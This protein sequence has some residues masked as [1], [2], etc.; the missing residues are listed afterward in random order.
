MRNLPDFQHE[1]SLQSAR[2]SYPFRSGDPFWV[3]PSTLKLA[4]DSNGKPVLNLEMVRQREIMLNSERNGRF[5]LKLEAEYRL[6]EVLQEL[7]ENYPNAQVAPVIISGGFLQ[8]FSTDSQTN[9]PDKLGK[10]IELGWNGLQLIYNQGRLD[11]SST[12]WVKSLIAE[13]VLTIQ[14]R[15]DVE[16]EGVAPRVPQIASFD[17][18][19]LVKDIYQFMPGQPLNWQII[20]QY[21]QQEPEQMAVSLSTAP[22][23]NKTA[24]Q[25]LARALTDRIYTRFGSLIPDP[26]RGTWPLVELNEQDPGRFDWDLSLVEQVRRPIIIMFSPLTA[27]KNYVQAHGSESLISSVTVPPIPPGIYRVNVSAVLP[28]KALNSYAFG[29]NLETKANLP[30][31]PAQSQGARFTD[32]QLQKNVNLRFLRTETPTYSA[33]TYVIFKTKQ[34]VKRLEKSVETD[35]DQTLTLAPQD[36][37]AR[38]LVVQATQQLLNAASEI[39][40]LYD[41]NGQTGSFELTAQQPAVSVLVDSDQADE[42]DGTFSIT[43]ISKENGFSIKTPPLTA[44]VRLDFASFRSYGPQKIDINVTFNPGDPRL[45]VFEFEGENSVNQV[46]LIFTPD[47]NQKVFRFVPKSPFLARYRYRVRDGE[48]STW[49]IDK[50]LQLI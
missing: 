35:D 6:S 32:S 48:W 31:R 50:R 33:K 27:I 38:F 44:P 17:P 3:W 42:I 13:G 9:L 18:Q 1:L 41:I 43:A 14:A 34:G 22:D 23:D 24:T 40:G 47:A 29:V 4:T 11:K 12:E 36:F 37:P 15:A 30:R 16:V 8:F 39:H 45:K 26:Y 28:P 49:Q 25:L 2:L 46:T 10:P 19:H 20:Y 21:F 5:T 7:R